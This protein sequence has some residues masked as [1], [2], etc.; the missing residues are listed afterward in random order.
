ME[1]ISTVLSTHRSVDLL[2]GLSQLAILALHFESRLL[3]F[4]NRRHPG[5][6]SI[7]TS[8]LGRSALLGPCEAHSCQLQGFP[9][10]TADE[11]WVCDRLS[12]FEFIDL[13]LLR[14]R[15][16]AEPIS[17]PRIFENWMLLFAL[18]GD[19]E[20]QRWSCGAVLP[21]M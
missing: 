14:G 11:V 13:S 2:S 7:C 4:V 16:G 9:L 8:L 1:R 19:V 21:L 3:R 5:D 12:W 6:L 18:D 15:R 20:R 10:V 17:E